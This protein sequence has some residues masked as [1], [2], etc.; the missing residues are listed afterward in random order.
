MDLFPTTPG[1][2]PFLQR[3]SDMNSEKQKNAIKTRL[4]R[5]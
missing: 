3:L 2:N 4:I 1:S 5:M